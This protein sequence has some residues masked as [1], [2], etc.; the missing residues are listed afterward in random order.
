MTGFVA[1]GHKCPSNLDKQLFK[2]PKW[3]FCASL[4]KSFHTTFY[5]WRLHL[6]YQ[7]NSDLLL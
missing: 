1:Q 7:K 2:N 6:F 3:F 5:S 4:W